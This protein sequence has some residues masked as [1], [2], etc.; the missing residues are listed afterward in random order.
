MKVD[1]S[2]FT[3][4][5]NMIYAGFNGVVAGVIAGFAG[6]HGDPTAFVLTFIIYFTAVSYLFYLYATRDRLEKE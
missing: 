5:S 1:S 3:K 2:F 6:Y 4:V